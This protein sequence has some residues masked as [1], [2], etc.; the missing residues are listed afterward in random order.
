MEGRGC[1]DAASEGLA[2]TDKALVI[3]Y[4]EGFD[5]HYSSPNL[6]LNF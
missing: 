3:G 1:V 2:P 5:G 6:L 4:L